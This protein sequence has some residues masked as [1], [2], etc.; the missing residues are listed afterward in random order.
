MVTE[1]KSSCKEFITGKGEITS[2]IMVLLI[3]KN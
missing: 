1:D 3:K 2:K